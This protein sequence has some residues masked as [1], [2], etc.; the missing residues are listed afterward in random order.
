MWG[1]HFRDANLLDLL[2][3]QGLGHGTNLAFNLLPYESVLQEG[4]FIPESL[5]M[6]LFAQTGVIGSLLFIVMNVKIYLG[7]SCRYKTMIPV[8]MFTG[9]TLNLLELFPINWIYMLL[10]GVCSQTAAGRAPV[11]GRTA[12]NA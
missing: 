2:I 6:S 7:S 11:E 12:A 9:L 8:L 4:A 3:G 1:F 10:L 5:Y